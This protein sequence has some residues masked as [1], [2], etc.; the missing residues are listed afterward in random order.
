MRPAT[1][2]LLGLLLVSCAD[3]QPPALATLPA[4]GDHVSAMRKIEGFLDL[5][6]DADAGK[7]LLAVP[8]VNEPFIYVSG[9]AH[10]VGSNDLGL[11]RGQLGDSKLVYFFRSG[12]KVLL[13]EDNVSYVASSDNPD[14]RRAVE[15][16]FARSVLW[17][18]EA[19]AVEGATVLVDAT[20]FFLRDAHDL[21]ATL[22]A[23]NEGDYQA[24]ATRSAIYL[25]QT[26]GFPDN[27]EIEAV[28]TFT[29]QPAGK[30]LSTVTPD[31]RSV[32]VHMHHSFVRLP[33]P[34]YE[35][36]PYDPR[37]GYID[38]DT[39]GMGFLRDYAT[40]IGEPIERPLAF[41]HR[42]KKKKPKAKLSAAV[43]PIVYYVDRGTP[44]PIRSALM[45]GAAWWADAFVAAGYK[46]AFKIELLPE[47]ASPLDVRYNVIQWVHRS[48]RGWSYG[49][50]V[51]DPRTGEII[52]GHVSLGSLR[53]RQDYLLAEGLLAPY[54]DE[55]IP[56]ELL[57]FALA[58][59]RQLAAH[60][61]GHTLGL[62]HNF[63]ASTDQR[64]SVM[65]YPHP[66]V[67]LDDEDNID[68]SSAY[69]VGVGA[70]DKRAILYGY[71]DFPKQTDIAQE[72]ERILLET[73]ASG[74]DFVADVHSRGDALARTAGPA[75]PLGSL[76][77]NGV[78][79]VAELRQLMR[80]RRQ[81]L[82][83]FSE[84][85]IRLGRPM[86]SIEEALVPMYL[87]H[88]YQV[89]AAAKFIGGRYFSY[90][91]RGDGLTPTAPV[92]G[93]KQRDAVAAI[94]ETLHPLA[95]RLDP[96]LIDLIPPRPPG[97]GPT[98]E[99]FPRQTGYLFDPLAAA[100][101]AAGMTIDQLLDPTRGA[102]MINANMADNAQ[103]G[104]DELV[105]ALLDATWY[106]ASTE[107]DA[108]LQRLVETSVLQRLMALAAN[109]DAQPQVRAIAFDRLTDLHA[110]IQR[111][112][113]AATD[114]WRAHYRFSADQVQ[115]FMDDP[116]AVAPLRP[117]PPPPGS[118]I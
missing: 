84:R 41:R 97:Q 43:E 63:A 54:G 105:D 78:D 57:E 34:G 6:W 49:W 69:G 17:G 93:D 95:L 85:N 45:E 11:D 52:K 16:S 110:W 65:D 14:E 66:L 40:P 31:A 79:A 59:I 50:S 92:P 7:L 27:T 118:P 90:A 12:P 56:P 38:P 1:C 44:E 13:V 42:L 74:L 73:Y 51:A 55:N 83:N 106:S 104:F 114:G 109:A 4:L 48:T 116:A 98:R 19:V 10:G 101:T 53:V 99:L 2:L 21:A 88:R 46:D 60:E 80:V 25:P 96:A 76:W 117:V 29:G 39:W 86:A 108:G 71:Q 9:L 58:R 77:D 113:V 5:Y 72:R 18:F 61:V 112:E 107:R 23:A 28:V 36:L 89:Q 87:L 115:R 82:E 70:W 37:A 20:D 91:L 30:I 33:P 26:A 8:A 111:R 94:L 100:A 47:E 3:D 35:P 32:T 102:R 22:K 67:R 68:I 64:A 24:D 75:H 103:P 15:Q 62:G 81:V